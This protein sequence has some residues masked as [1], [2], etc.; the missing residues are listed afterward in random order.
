MMLEPVVL[1]EPDDD[2]AH[3]QNEEDKDQG[4]D[5]EAFPVIMT[6]FPLCFYP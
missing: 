2:D 5:Q 6:L 1:L 3:D 4:P